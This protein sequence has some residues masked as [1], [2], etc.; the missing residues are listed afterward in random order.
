M[1]INNKQCINFEKYK[2]MKN[3]NNKEILNSLWLTIKIA[4]IVA[5][6]FIPI[7]NEYNL[8]SISTLFLISFIYSFVLGFGQKFGMAL[9]VPYSMYFLL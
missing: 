3:I 5:I 8:K 6:I 7:N 1:L 9:F 2:K 4:L